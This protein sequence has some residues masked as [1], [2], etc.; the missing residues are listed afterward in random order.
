M[1]REP[2]RDLRLFVGRLRRTPWRRMLSAALRPRG[3]HGMDLP[4]RLEG[5]VYGHL[6]G[7][8]LGV[9][10]EFLEPGAIPEVTWRG[11]GGHRQP[12]GTWSDDGALMLALLDSLL[13]VAPGG[14]FDTSDQAQ[15]ALA[16]RDEGRYAPGSLVFDVGIATTAALDALRAGTPPEEAGAVDA[17]GNGSLMRILGLPL[18]VR[19]TGD[20]ELI[21]LASR[22][23]R[24]THGSAEAQLACALYALIVRRVLAGEADRVA[25]MSAAFAAVRALVRA[26]GLPGSR[27]AADPKAALA[28]LDAFEA[29]PRREGSGRVV[30]SFWS[31]WDAFAGAPDYVATVTAA[32]SYGHDTDTTAAIAG[33]L[34]GA[35]WGLASIPVSW[36]RDLRDPG[37]VRPI[38]D[39]LVQTDVPVREQDAWRTSSASPLRVD[40]VDLA[41]TDLGNAG[42]SMGMTFLPGKRCIGTYSGPAWRD[43]DS[44]AVS[45]RAQGVDVLLLLVEDHE[46]ERCRVTDIVAVLAH[47][48]IEVRRFPIEDPMLPSDDVGFRATLA[49]L[50]GCVRAGA[51]L[52][53]ACRGGL[54]RSGMTMGCLLREAGIDADD[55]IR[56]VHDARRHTLTLP[57]QLRYVRTWGHPSAAVDIKAT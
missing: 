21:R 50:V 56:R 26:E 24:V 22:A 47:H 38:V 27:E 45:L 36:R 19:D 1:S 41:G 9:P 48:G 42:G 53:V 6:V 14:G 35:H 7:D 10:Y 37:I 12:P 28:Q 31:A 40:R 34:A 23:S 11:G 29:W 54:D 8:A 2:D 57:H 49:D 32:V 13:S 3:R 18:V 46:L 17:K 33:G 44:D 4:D 43:L 30:D 55:A 52:A 5:A 20:E 15:R 16:W 51:G 39:R 25:V